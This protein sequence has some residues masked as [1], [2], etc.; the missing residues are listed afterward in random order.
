[1]DTGS[2]R[3]LRSEANKTNDEQEWLS[4]DHQAIVREGILITSTHTLVIGSKDSLN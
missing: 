4:S 2:S 3:R 1:M